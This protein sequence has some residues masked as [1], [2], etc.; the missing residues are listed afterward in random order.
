MIIIIIIAAAKLLP[1]ILQLPN[2]LFFRSS[3]LSY[4]NFTHELLNVPTYNL[5][6][7]RY[8]HL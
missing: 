8:L 2:I 3:F 4:F 5:C 1:I 7:I 6:L